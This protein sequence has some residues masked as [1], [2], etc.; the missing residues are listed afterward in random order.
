MGQRQV[1]F[2]SRDGIGFMLSWI[3]RLK[4]DCITKC[5][6]IEITPLT[7]TNLILLTLR[8]NYIFIFEN[9]NYYLFIF[10]VLLNYIVLYCNLQ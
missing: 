1:S 6:R 5:N 3:G 8:Y 10:I 2:T 7:I 4:N 9:Y